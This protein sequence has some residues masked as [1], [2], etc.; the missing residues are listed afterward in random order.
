MNSK[1]RVC[2]MPQSH[3]VSAVRRVI[4]SLPNYPQLTVL[5]LSCGE[6]ELLARLHEDGCD[7][8]GSRFRGD[9]Y[10]IQRHGL[11]GQLE[12]DEGVD[13]NQPLPYANDHFDLVVMTEVLEH[14]GSHLPVI[15][16]VGRVLKPGGHFVFTSPNIQRV[17]SRWRFFLTGTHKLIRR[18]VGWDLSADDLYAYHINPVSFPLMHTLLFQGGMRVAN[19]GYT[20]FKM[21]HAAWM[22]IYP[23]FWLAARMTIGGKRRDS[24][25]YRDGERDLRRWMTHPAMLSS[26]QLLVVARRRATSVQSVPSRQAA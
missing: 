8:R 21:R 19:L 23:L 12:I 11:V 17:H 15:R 7:C 26:E 6:G 2:Y 13:L 3:I 9:D 16:E 25:A 10:I 18:R 22:L 4:A 5:D 14:L 20:A 1:A 24:Q